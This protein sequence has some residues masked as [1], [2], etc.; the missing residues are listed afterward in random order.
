MIKTES[1]V[2]LK[3]FLIYVLPFRWYL[4]PAFLCMMLL[5][6]SN[7]AIAF[8]VQ[9]ILD[10]VFIAKN[11]TMIYQVPLVILLI[12]AGRAVASFLEDYLMEYVGLKVV[13]TLQVN[14]YRHILSLDLQYLMS[15]TTGSMISRVANDT[16]LL[17][18]SA[19]SVVA[20]IFQEGMTVL[21]LFGVVVYRDA[22]LAMVFCLALPF[23]TY[24]I[25][26]FGR[27]VRTLSRSRQEMM[28]DVYAHLEESISGLRIV[29]AFCMESFERAAFRTIT[30]QV[31]T[32]QLRSAVVRALTNP[33]MDMVAG[34]AISGVVLYGGQAVISGATTPGNFFSFITALL[35]AY[36]PIKR[37]ANLNNMLQESLAAAHRVF[38]LLDVEPTIKNRPGAAILPPMQQTIQ[39]QDVSFAYGPGLPAVLQQ[40]NLTVKAGEKV[41]LVGSSGAGKT[42]LIHL[43]PRFFDVTEGRILVD[44]V[45]VRT[46]TLASLRA[47]IAIVTQEVVLF[48]DTVRNNIAYGDPFRT[49]EEVRQ[50]AIEA[51]ALDFIEAMPDGFDTLIGDRG[52]KLSGGQKQRL[53]IARSLIKNAPILILDEATSALDTESERAVQ[54]ALE[55]LMAA[56]TTLVI[57]HRLSTIRNA[58]RIVVLKAGQIVEIGN[59]D[60]LLALDGEYARFYALQFQDAPEA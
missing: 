19:S 50:A 8:Y 17:K 56:R 21:F 24:L 55:R 52:V 1:I 20:N 53:S 16:L 23:V 42:T 15:R 54:D 14:L 59:H 36:T 22:E 4:L 33:S 48:N 44:G 13:R 41:A 27:R 60:A 29:K 25:V 45:D 57:A 18:G 3:R 5:A 12:F 46:V 37:F 47:Q 51:N 28:E 10:E 6:A 49:L 11:T 39:F 34:L 30:K 43:V 58:D 9:P 7:S 32:N 38:E 2:I 26:H 35:M 40:I 31:L